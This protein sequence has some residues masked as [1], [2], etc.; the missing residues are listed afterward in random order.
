ML[1]SYVGITSNQQ[2]R[3]IRQIVPYG[4]AYGTN[5]GINQQQPYYLG[6]INPQVLFGFV[7]PNTCVCSCSSITYN[8]LQTC[9]NSQA[10]LLSCSTTYSNCVSNAI[11]AVCCGSD[12][13]NYG[14]TALAAT[15]TDQ[16]RCNCGGGTYY[17][18]TTTSS[19][20]SSP[21]SCAQTCMQAYPTLCYT[22]NTQGCCGMNCAMYSQTAS[23]CT[24]YCQRGTFNPAPSCTNGQSCMSTCLTTYSECAPRTTQACCGGDCANYIPTCRCDC[25]NGFDQLTSIPCTSGQSCVETCINNYGACNRENIVASCA[26]DI[27]L[28]QAPM[29]T[30][31][32]GSISMSNNQ[33]CFNGQTCI[34]SCLQTL[35]DSQQCTTNSIHAC[36]GSNNCATYNTPTCMCQCQDSKKYYPQGIGACTDGV[37]CEGL[38]INY[39]PT[40]KSL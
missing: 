22:S 5:T 40:D 26:G 21:L 4:N 1:V 17:P 24:C 39:C 33:Q 15:N 19:S 31:N 36:C 35:G 34:Q 9:S 16:C 38:C 18:P 14:N 8:P 11:Q 25:G 30:C 3:R 13:I 6:N 32:C 37:S 12:C 7:P 10:C 27:I 29:C 23:I 20:C 2:K 28:P